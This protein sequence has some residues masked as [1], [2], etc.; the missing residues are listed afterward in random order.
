MSVGVKVPSMHWNRAGLEDACTV[1]RQWAPL[2]PLKILRRHLKRAL[3]GNLLDQ[4]DKSNMVPFRDKRMIRTRPERKPRA[5]E[6]R[7]RRRTGIS[8]SVV[9]YHRYLLRHFPP[10]R[11][12]VA[13]SR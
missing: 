6:R 12:F 9:G 3:A 1:R 13:S 2:S 4:D 5:S 8:S 7:G 11:R 10:L